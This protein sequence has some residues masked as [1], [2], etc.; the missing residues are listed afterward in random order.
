MFQ[1]PHV[2]FLE[3]TDAVSVLLVGSVAVG[4][5]GWQEQ[6]ARQLDRKLGGQVLVF[7]SDAA[8]A[9]VGRVEGVPPQQ[10]VVAVQAAY[11]AVDLVVAWVDWGPV[12]A[13]LE[14][15]LWAHTKRRS[16]LIWGVSDK[17]RDSYHH[18]GHLLQV[19]EE[20]QWVV[21]ATLDDLQSRVETQLQGMRR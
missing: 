7:R 2:P 3:D 18:A 12:W 20:Q 19:L 11:D 5:C 17:I 21:S 9:G 15:G 1:L 6:M 10:M 8:V 13:W 4:G 14:F 16:R